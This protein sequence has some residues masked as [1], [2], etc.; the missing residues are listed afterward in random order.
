MSVYKSIGAD[1][2]PQERRRI[3]GAGVLLETDA[4]RRRAWECPKNGRVV[5]LKPPLY[6]CQTFSPIRSAQPLGIWQLGSYLRARGHDVR[7]IDCV[8]EGWENKA[9]LENGKPYDFARAVKERV[10][11]LKAAGPEAV[12]ARYPVTDPEGRISRTL[13][14]TGLPEDGVVERMRDM[15]PGWIGISII[16]SCEHRSAIDLAKRLRREFPDAVMV[17][18]GQHATDMAG[19][20]LADSEGAIDIV[21]KGKGEPTFEALLKGER[22]ERG[23]AYMDRGCLVEQDDAPLTPLGILPPLDPG[24]LA[25]INYPLPAPHSYGTGGRRYTDFMTSFGCHCKCDFCRAPAA[26]ETYRHFALPQVEAQLK[27]LKE[28][29]YGELILQDDS[30]LGGPNND[31]RGFFLEIVKLFKRFGFHWHD[32]GGVQFERIDAEVI[33]SILRANDMK[34][35][36][37]CTALYVPTNPRHLM[38]RN[39]MERY[40][41][42]MPEKLGLLKKLKENGIYIF[43]SW[44]WG[45]VNQSPRDMES[46]I[47]QYEGLLKDGIVDQVIVFGL[48]YLPRTADWRYRDLIVDINDW[49]GYSIFTPHAGTTQASFWDVNL[50][51]LEAYRRLNALQPHV[52]PWASGFPPSV[53][54]GWK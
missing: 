28:N 45:H 25:H 29:G 32:N 49:E 11:T 27:I 12:L 15:D 42:R 38:D 3:A 22:P 4:G 6:T 50:A 10:G 18:G 5:L 48:S 14:R 20:V 34:G 1:G 31:G 19:T 52:E 24:L 39:V 7:V 46:N 23:I 40:K 8:I 26:N 9:Y 54:E 44:I 17:A 41:E 51:V 37:R 35:E 21:V 43:T 47:T 30:L 13:I 2:V 36:G 53:P 16:A 33:D